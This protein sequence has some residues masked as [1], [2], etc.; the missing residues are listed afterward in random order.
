MGIFSEVLL[1]M[2]LILLQHGYTIAILKGDAENRLKH[3]NTLELAQIENT[4]Q[5][6]IDLVAQNVAEALERLLA[7]L[8]G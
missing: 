7:T 8:K 1:L 2:N 5:P 6:F 3:Y 4:K